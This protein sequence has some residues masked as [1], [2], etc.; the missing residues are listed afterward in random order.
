MSNAA[1]TSDDAALRTHLAALL[2]TGESA[3]GRTTFTDYTVETMGSR[4]RTVYEQCL[5]ETEPAQ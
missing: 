4:L 1:V 2:E 5:R 3:D